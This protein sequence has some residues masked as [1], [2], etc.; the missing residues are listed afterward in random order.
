M[1][2]F[3]RKPA[4]R[5]GVYE[6]FWPETLRDYWPRQGYPKG[7]NPEVHFDYDIMN[8]GG[9]FDSA[10][11]QGQEVMLEET[12]EWKVVKDGR[13]ASLKY[14]K[15]KSGTPEHI[16]FEVTSPE[17][18]KRYRELLLPTDRSRI[19]FEGSR[20]GMAQARE[21]GKFC[22][23]GNLFVFELLRGTL[24][25]EHFLPALLEEPEWIRDFCEVYLDFFKRHYTLLFD[26]VGVPDGM[27]I[28]EDLGYRNGLFCS[29]AVLREMILPYHKQLVEFFKS[30]GLLVMLH[31]C[32]DIRRALPMIVEAGWDCLQPM[33]AKAGCD[34]VELAQ[35][36]GDRLTFMGNI[37]VTVLNKNDKDKIREEIEGKVRA[38][39]RLGAS[40]LLHS[41]HSIPPDISYESY[42]F[43][44][45]VF[46]ENAA[47]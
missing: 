37:D 3:R 31:S 23:Y 10:P 17:I 35:Q 33:E 38:L 26:E 47:R 44:L 46:W 27:F 39:K 18:W 32:G 28:Y 1:N 19:D 9:W 15:N 20:R 24:G 43:M 4:E 16:G 22:V 8:V 42:K 34:V 6:H 2:L 40:Y 45:D 30:Y 36:Y 7:V 5:Y 21:R 13:G 14:W 29:P 25:D 11:Y 41:D 12:A